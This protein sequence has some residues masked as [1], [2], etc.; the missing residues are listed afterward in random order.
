MSGAVGLL[1]DIPAPR[2]PCLR[3]LVT[4]ARASGRAGAV[5][6]GPSIDELDDTVALG[7]EGR[8]RHVLDGGVG[9]HQ[10]V[11]LDVGQTK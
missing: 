7:A 8:H 5:R 1:A 11:E 9:R 4:V 6:R 2:R 10:M 3:P